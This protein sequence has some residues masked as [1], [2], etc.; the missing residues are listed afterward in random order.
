MLEVCPKR[1]TVL[2]AAADRKDFYHQIHAPL[3]KALCN[4][5]GPALPL[6]SIK[7][8]KA[9]AAYKARRHRVYDE[10]SWSSGPASEKTSLL[11]E[12]DHYLVCFGAIAQGDHLGV[13]IG[14]AAH[15]ALLEG[16]GLLAGANR[17]CSNL[18][19]KGITCAQG[20][21]IDD[22][23]SVCVHDLASQQEP[24]CLQHLRI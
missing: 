22:F 13:E 7:H 2:C 14:T 21:V 6:A 19:F 10:D 11:F 4:A 23:F 24:E 12:P 16:D 1:Q 18:P 3:P 9:F 5:L 15:S 17:L 20:L 8:T